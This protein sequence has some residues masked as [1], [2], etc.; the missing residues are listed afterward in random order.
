MKNDSSQSDAHRCMFTIGTALV[1]IGLAYLL[2]V[3]S[4]RPAHAN[5]FEQ[6]G[7]LYGCVVTWGIVCDTSDTVVGTGPPLQ[8]IQPIPVTCVKPLLTGLPQFLSWPK[9]SAK[10]RFQSTCSSPAR[11]GAVMIVRWEGSWTPS[12]TAPDR[13]NA[14]ETLEITGFEPFL[15]N[16]E[17]GGKIFMFFTARCTR[18]PWLQSGGC[19]PWGAYVPD[20]LRQA[21]PDIDK[22]SFPR[23]GNVIAAADKR[24]LYAEYLRINPPS[25][26]SQLGLVEGVSASSSQHK[27]FAAPPIAVEKPKVPADQMMQSSQG[28]L[29]DK[30][31]DAAQQHSRTASPPPPPPPPPNAPSVQIQKKPSNPSIFTRGLE[32]DEETPLPSESSGSAGALAIAIDRPLHFLSANGEDVL[33]QAG[34]YEIEPVLDQQ[35]ALSGKDQGPWLLDALASTHTETIEYTAALLVQAQPEDRWHMV[36]LTPAGTRLDAVGTTS[37]VQARGIS[38]LERAKTSNSANQSRLTQAAVTATPAV[39]GELQRLADEQQRLKAELDP[40]ALLARIKHLESLLACLYIAGP[41]D[42]MFQG[43]VFP[44]PKAYPFASLDARWDGTKCPGQ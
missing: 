1:A 6:L 18:D 21:L 15:P 31:N 28:S 22:Q 16:R 43:Y 3:V 5:V 19:T 32:A 35:L 4:P 20:D 7:K 11:P 29:K 34:Q 33:V 37:E 25:Y 40:A 14:S 30:L 41:G 27:Y 9:G 42:P 36:Y 23:T 8:P 12:E 38:P 17:S 2:C 39:K 13:P 24:R 44:G 10:Y 26:F